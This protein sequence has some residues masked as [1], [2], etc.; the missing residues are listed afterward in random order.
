MKAKR[1]RLPRKPAR[2]FESKILSYPY[3]TAAPL[4][5]GLGAAA[6]IDWTGFGS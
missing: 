2:P 1:P 4:G 6:A 5:F 3:R